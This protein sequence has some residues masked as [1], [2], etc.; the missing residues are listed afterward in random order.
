MTDQVGLVRVRVLY[1]PGEDY[2]HSETLWAE[3]VDA[4]DGGGTYRL[5]NH[6]FM[7][8]LAAGDLV[9][10]ELD[11]HGQLQVVD[12]VQPGAGLLTVV[13]VDG[14]RPEEQVREALDRWSSA[15]AGWTEGTAGYLT[16]VWAPGMGRPDIV[17]VLAADIDAGLV[18]PELIAVPE[19]RTRRALEDDV[20]F[21]L[22]RTPPEEVR[23]S[24]WAAEDP[25][26]AELGKHDPEFLAFVQRL[27]SEDARVARA[28][29]KGQHDR[30]STY[31]ERITAE[32]PRTLPPL[33]GPIFEE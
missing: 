6:A 2:P 12:I 19:E 28:L 11:G 23:T 21:E 25:V 16:T 32:D 13:E 9:R 26:W 18:R 8:S 5:E 33:D 15:G 14:S 17:A 4:N 31:I 7:V 29:E 30:V 22:D 24:Y 20:D 3:P 1:R 10:A 27:A